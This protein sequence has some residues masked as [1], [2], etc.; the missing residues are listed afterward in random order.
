MFDVRSEYLFAYGSLMSGIDIE[1][2][3]LER[4]SLREAGAFVSP[5]SI[6]GRMI[7]VGPFPAAVTSCSNKHRIF[8]ELWRISSS[9]PE[10]WAML[11]RYEGCEPGYSGPYAY[12]RSKRRVACCDGHRRMAWVYVWDRPTEGFPQINS[13]RWQPKISKPF[14]AELLL[15]NAA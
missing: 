7:D 4:R 9:A 13:G 10:L 5:G 15:R 14:R 3:R 8:G 12:R 6:R 11:N 2:G 1:A